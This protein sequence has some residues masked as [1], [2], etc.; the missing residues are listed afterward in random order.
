VEGN[1]FAAGG[2]FE[3]SKHVW[4]LAAPLGTATIDCT[5]PLGR[6]LFVAGLTIEC[7]SLEPLESGFHGDTEEE[8]AECA[9]YWADHIEGVLRD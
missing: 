8:Q 9:T 6:L 5:I 1:P 3:L 7:S 2:C 4:A